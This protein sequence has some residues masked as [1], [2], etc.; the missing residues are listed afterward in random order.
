M[1]EQSNNGWLVVGVST[2]QHSSSAIIIALHCIVHMY[3]ISIDDVPLTDHGRRFINDHVLV[4]DS[5]NE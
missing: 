4:I 3:W 5:C 1:V 2:N